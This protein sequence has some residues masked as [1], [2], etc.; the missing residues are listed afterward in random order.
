MNAFKISFDDF[1]KIYNQ[2][3]GEPEFEITFNDKE[4]EY[5]IIKY[6]DY[7]TFQRCGHDNSGS[8]EIKYKSLDDMYE[9]VLVDNI[10]LKKDWEKIA[11]AMNNL[12]EAKIYIDDTAGCTITDLRAKCR[13]LA[14]A[15]KY[16]KLSE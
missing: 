13:R 15:E 4:S 16:F 8:G 2:I 7:V 11:V 14:M 10:S 1:R 12:S 3:N 9:S 6:D 5:M